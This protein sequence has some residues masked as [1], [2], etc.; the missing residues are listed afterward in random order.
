MENRKSMGRKR[1]T[2]HKII[3]LASI[4]AFLITGCGK[5]QG[6]GGQ[7][8]PGI[9]VD[10]ES[11]GTEEGLGADQGQGSSEGQASQEGQERKGGPVIWQPAYLQLEK[12]YTQILAADH[13]LYGCYTESGQMLLDSIEKGSLSANADLSAKTVTLPHI[14]MYSG[15]AADP[16][17]YAYF[18]EAGEGGVWLCRIDPRTDASAPEKIEL[19][20]S[21][22]VG[23][24]RLKA[25]M[26]DERG[27]LYIWCGLSIPRTERIDGVESQIWSEADRVYVMNREWETVFYEEILDVSGVQV[28]CFQI[29][30]DGV[31][32]FLLKDDLEICVQEI[33]VEGQQGKEKLSLGS[34]LDCFD[35]QDANIPEHMAYT[36]SGWVYCRNGWLLEFRQDT[37][38]KVQIL[39][40]ASDGILSE[41]ILFLAKNEDRIEII[42]REAETGALEYIVFTPGTSDKKT[43]TLGVTFMVQDL[44]RAVAEFNRS[45]TGYKVEIVDY[46]SRTGDYEEASEQLK[47][48][49]VTGK[50]PDIIAVSGMDYQMFTGK[51]VLADLYDF[52]EKDGEC[53]KDMLVESVARACED[54]GH[55]YTIAPSFQLHTM[56]G[57]SD[58]TGG[59]SGVTFSQLLKILQDK[60]KDFNAIGGFSADEPVLNWL[61]AVAMDEFVDWET[62][63]CAFDGD[64]FKEVLSFVGG[65]SP[66]YMEGSY[67]ERIHSRVQVMTVGILTSM[68]EYQI[69]KQLYGGELSFIGYPVAEG[70]GTVVDYQASAVGI[71][72]GGEEQA[73]AWAFVKFYLMKGYDGQGFPVVKQ[74][75]DQ[76]MEDAMQD[77]YVAAEGGGTEKLPKGY[78]SD[79]DSQ[80]LAYAATKEEVDAIRGLVDQVE[81]RLKYHRGIEKII[82]E[83]AQG[84]LSGQVDLDRT[85]EKI[86]NRVSILLQESL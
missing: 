32:F 37:Q 64:Y 68:A 78:Y 2:R 34:T 62:G 33:D 38:E 8:L 24:M 28:L 36:G 19:K 57:Y 70:S 77:D 74:Q 51:A 27:Y 25:V 40:L 3:V 69:Q 35:M 6:S 21:Q 55:L 85:A 47:L 60:G 72:A 75:F 67:S 4:L 58:V 43:V 79:G 71:N 18:L 39:N 42:D 14:D 30:P 20:D 5:E 59:R 54:Q 80:I 46:Y 66:E 22:D 49:L 86:Q 29:G 31:P 45:S 52:M 50:A 1:K 10:L 63:T 23:D 56:W 53:S 82:N 7:G 16:E 17:G 76:A 84:Y 13:T 26:A 48:A 9:A 11:P 73:G 41:D 65:Y 61:C 83:E 15:I 12:P 44:E 81:N